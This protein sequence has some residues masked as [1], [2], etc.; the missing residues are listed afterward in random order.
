MYA[1]KVFSQVTGDTVKLSAKS[2]VLNACG[3]K[4]GGLDPEFQDLI[5]DYD[6]FVLLKP[7]LTLLV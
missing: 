2:A 6:L 3:L 1:G 5:S 4:T 7:N